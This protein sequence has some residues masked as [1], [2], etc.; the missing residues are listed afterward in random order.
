MCQTLIDAQ[1]DDGRI[2]A[3]FNQTGTFTGRYSSSSPNLQNIP[4]GATALL[5]PSA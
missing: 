4:R 2:Y 1:R 3:R 5:L